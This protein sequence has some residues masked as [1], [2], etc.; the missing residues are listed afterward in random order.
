MHEGILVASRG[1]TIPPPMRRI[2]FRLL[3]VLAT[4]AAT[5]ALAE[6]VL[7]LYIRAKGDDSG[8]VRSILAKSANTSVADNA[9]H[10]GKFSLSGLVK[11]SPFPDVVYELKPNVSGTFRGKSLRTNAQGLRG[12]RDYPTPKSAGTFRIAGLGDS[13]MFGWGVGEGE[14]YLEIVERELAAR[15]RPADV[16][17]FAVPGY[18]TSLE[19][20][21]FE[22]RALPFS[23][24]LVVLHFIGNDFG[25]PHFLRRPD[26]PLS[27]GGAPSKWLLVELLKMRF[28]PPSP[29]DEVDPDLIG[30][31]TTGGAPGERYEARKQYE[32]IVGEAAFVKALGRLRDLTQPR[33]IP[34]I[35][36]ALAG[37]EGRGKL[38]RETAEKNGFTFLNAAPH[39]YNYLVAHD[40]QHDRKNWVTVFRIPHD[41]HPN[42]L[43]HRLYAEVL[44]K[45]LARRGV[46][47]SA[48]SKSAPPKGNAS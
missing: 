36:M 28:T 37:D 27:R 44:L 13:V 19:V 14:P 33:G 43:G 11:A 42:S 32:G 15:G 45:E 7:R 9:E 6:G 17:S 10:G 46:V 16:L 26:A 21:A 2:V 20:A 35:V 29:D 30:H 38:A 25:L 34:V 40:L 18:N 39:F 47:K 5:L 41:G 8:D 48:P 12:S 24:D 3:V 1:R 31:D 23:P 22:H 4:I